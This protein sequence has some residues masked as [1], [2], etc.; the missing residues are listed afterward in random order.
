MSLLPL[1]EEY[2]YDASYDGVDITDPNEK[3]SLENF[4]A[5]YQPIADLYKFDDVPPV[6]IVSNTI[7]KLMMD[8]N[9]WWSK[10]PG[11]DIKQV[12]SAVNPS[13]H[14]SFVSSLS[15]FLHGKYKASNAGNNWPDEMTPEDRELAADDT[16]SINGRIRKLV[17]KYS[18]GMIAKYVG[19]KPSRVRQVAKSME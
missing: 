17:G 19:T 6:D 12:I 8:E 13:S 4:L 18:P 11:T 3:S 9:L 7:N 2:N 16:Q 1:F 15:K 14:E 10:N 5:D